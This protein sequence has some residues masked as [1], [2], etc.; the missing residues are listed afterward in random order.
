MLNPLF[1]QAAKYIKGRKL[2]LDSRVSG[3]YL[4]CI[5]LGGMFSLARGIFRLRR[6]VLLGKHVKLRGKTKMHLSKGVSIGDFCSLDAEGI[7][8]LYVGSGSSIGSFSCL[9][10][11]GTLADL[12]N[13]ISIGN[14]VGIGE[15]AHIGGA[16]GV[17]IGDDTITGAYLS[18]H[19][20]NHIFSN[21][22]VPIRQQGVTRKGISIGRNCWI[23]AKATF[24]DGARI[25]DGC[26]VA[27][28]TVVKGQFPDNTILAGVP[29]K[30][31]RDRSE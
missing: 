4:L 25:G 2:S 14:N 28:G 31:I 18:V 16:G 6:Q 19:P 8:G 5:A 20:E 21:I 15:F 29:A 12:G 9:K 3:G 24:L 10:V 1:Q 13:G 7:D 23:G 26:I 30:K 27:A 11:S 22:E 17:E